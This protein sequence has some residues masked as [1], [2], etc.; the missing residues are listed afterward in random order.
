MRNT[1]IVASCVVATAAILAGVAA[2]G[3]IMQPPSA[4]H[5]AGFPAVGVKPSLPTTGKL[6]VAFRRYT[7]SGGA[8]W[9]VFAD[10][11]II[12][13]RWTTSGDA[14]VAPK[15]V[16][17]L[18]TGYVE[19]RLTSEGIQL[20]RSKVLASGLFEDNLNLN[21]GGQRR[22]W[23]Y[24]QIRRDDDRMVTIAGLR[25]SAS[26]PANPDATPAQ[27]AA[28][29]QI[30]TGVA[31]LAA[32]LPTEAW[33]DREIRAFVPAHYL[34]NFDRGYPQ[35]SKMPSPARE[36]FVRY[37]RLRR[38]GCQILTTTQVRALLRA[39]VEAGIAPSNNHAS[40]IDFNLSAAGHPSEFH[41]IL[42]HPST[43]C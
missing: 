32:W 38:D 33:A 8:E 21:L 41:L 43:S 12:W 22:S 2:G 1:L 30:A 37:K 9:N 13:Q 16:R 17:R 36:V 3:P 7:D 42:A 19:Q 35:V 24:Y 40:W 25:G 15:G 11:R 20:L 39:F 5:F 14:E 10:G 6:V 4:T 18:D 31:D 26:E 23:V 28:L 27:A 29:A 34:A